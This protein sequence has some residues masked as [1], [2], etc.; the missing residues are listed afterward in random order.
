MGI[1]ALQSLHAL[2]AENLLVDA[3]AGGRLRRADVAIAGSV[4]H[5]LPLAI[6]Q[7]V[8]ECFDLMLAR[9]DAINDPFEQAFFIM[10]AYGD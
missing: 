5:P 10:A 8:E 7:R 9:A 2:L 3:A 4:L 1:E 6:P